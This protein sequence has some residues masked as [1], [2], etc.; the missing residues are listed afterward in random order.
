MWLMKGAVV[1]I[2][3]IDD[4][5]VVVAVVVVVVLVQLTTHFGVVE[6][7]FLFLRKAHSTMEAQ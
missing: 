1:I 6:M 7:R 3:I 5:V 4:V 2:M